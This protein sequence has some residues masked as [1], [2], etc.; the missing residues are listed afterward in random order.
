MLYTGRRVLFISITIITHERYTVIK[1]ITR[2]VET[3]NKMYDPFSPDS[4]LSSL[5]YTGIK[6]ELFSWK[7]N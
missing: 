2:F 4:L 1:Q 3:F 5:P 6:H 7:G